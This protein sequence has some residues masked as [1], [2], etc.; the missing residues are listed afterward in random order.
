MQNPDFARF[1]EA[2]PSYQS[3]AALDELRASQYTRLDQGA[4]V[5]LDY[6]GGGL[7]AESQVEAHQR[8]GSGR[9]HA[10]RGRHRACLEKR[11]VSVR[12]HMGAAAGFSGVLCRN[13][14]G[15][16]DRPPTPQ[17]DPGRVRAGRGARRAAKGSRGKENTA[18]GVQAGP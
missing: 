1:L 9:G 12:N 10:R 8:L 14:Y 4:H 15:K 6:T 5:Y 7:Y 2:Y 3:T 16:P 17:K 18:Y 13:Y 11:R